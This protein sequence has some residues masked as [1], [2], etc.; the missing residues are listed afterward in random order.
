MIS[1]VSRSRQS[2]RFGREFARSHFIFFFFFSPIAMA[3]DN[4]TSAMVRRQQQLKRWE[5]SDTNRE[6]NRVQ[7]RPK[8]VNFQDGCVFLAAC[9]SGDK[10]EVIKLLARGADI[11]TANVDG[12]TALHQGC[13]DDNL[14]MVEF[15]VQHHA[16]VDV[17][18]NEGWTPLHATASCGFINI[19]QY[20][21]N[22]GAN[23]AAVNNDGDLPIDICEDKKMERLLQEEMNSQGVDAEAARR[24][25]EDLMLADA[26]QWINSKGGVQENPHPK[27]GATALHVAAA[28][29]YIKVIHLLIQAKANVNIKD[30]DGW[31]PLH[32]AAHWGQDKACKILSENLCDMDIKNNV[33]QTAFDVADSDL[34]P[35]LEELKKKQAM[36][37]DQVASH[38]D[39]EIIQ[40]KGMQIKRR[41]SVTRM[42][43]DQ[44]QNVVLR[45]G[46]QERQDLVKANIFKKKDEDAK[47]SSSSS[48]S[49]ES[50][51]DSETE[52][53]NAI[54]ENPSVTHTVPSSLGQ[55]P[56]QAPASTTTT[57]SSSS[58]SSSSITTTPSTGKSVTDSRLWTRIS[59]S[60]IGSS[61]MVP[62]VVIPE[63]EHEPNTISRSASSPRLACDAHDKTRARRPF[64]STSS[65]S[66]VVLQT[67]TPARKT[68][69]VS[70][71]ATNNERLSSQDLNRIQYPYRQYSKHY[72]PFYLRTEKQKS[73]INTTLASTTTAD[74][75]ANTTTTTTAA[76]TDSTTA[77]T[78]TTTT[79]P[80]ATTKV[81]LPV[82][83]KTPNAD[84]DNDI[85]PTTTTT[86]PTTSSITN[87]ASS[88]IS[89]T[90]VT[91]P[92]AV[93]TSTSVTGHL[94]NLSSTQIRRSYEPPKR[95]EETE[96]Q[97]KARAK[98][99][100]ETRR[101]TQGV[102]M[103]E[104]AMAEKVLKLTREA[105]EKENKEKDTV[106][107]NSDK[108]DSPKERLSSSE[109]KD[110][111]QDSSKSEEV[112][113][114]TRR[115]WEERTS[116]GTQ[117]T[118]RRSR[119]QDLST[120]ST[121]NIYSFDTLPHSQRNQRNILSVSDISNTANSSSV[122][123]NRTSLRNRFQNDDAEKKQEEETKDL[124]KDSKEK[125]KDSDKR[126]SS[127]LKARRA[128]RERRSTGVI[129]YQKSEE[130][131]KA[132][133]K[134]ENEVDD[135][136]GVNSRISSSG[137]IRCGSTS[138]ITP[139]S[140]DRQSRTD[141]PSSYLG[142]SKST[143][144]LETIDYKKLYESEKE[145]STRL[146]KELE[147]IKKDLAITRADMEKL[148]RS[149]ETISAESNQEK[150]EKRG[151]ERKV[152]ELESTVVEMENLRSM[153]TRLKEEN[154][155]LIRVISKLSK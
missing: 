118:Y 1:R 136:R 33:G 121:P 54:N 79:T 72:V 97:R 10:D 120:S 114:R 55:Q 134:E 111:P 108:N 50:S 83:E 101:S 113:L 138:D 61:S 67:D 41:T 14:D 56:S 7:N 75:T 84:A 102:T 124:N 11:N 89:T 132:T 13:I 78:T 40:T 49:D 59:L 145:D 86:P 115:P 105:E 16:D 45:T 103:E 32:A 96:T 126:E 100:R 153:N 127:A 122:G 63:H 19:A 104:I 57:T 110:A 94:A 95:D 91:T 149:H 23:I 35:L 28:K 18:D 80:T 64:S 62:A 48:A 38:R 140:T 131:S 129:E 144:S 93:T 66:G 9:S 58:S 8:K 37:K 82:P 71:A 107:D 4:K 147:Q 152:S 141:R 85:T 30:F 98:R 116:A 43:V 119:D 60:K 137:T 81:S 125:E 3:D 90:K 15:L 130:D 151:L 42:S 154:G 27:T 139:S 155:A 26:N 53:Q 148:R 2:P 117:A 73:A 34:F 51:S 68:V 123:F 133:T 31:T 143:P 21:I 36:L 99:A 106:K 46:E 88:T 142:L 109:N 22:T 29:G 74:A 76:A 150:R 6:S 25:E 112:T 70:P 128:R 12:L 92:S 47:K 87:T 20:L 77:T 69:T 39:K 135:N 24:E 17:C 44:K 5:D 52:H 65:V 146:K